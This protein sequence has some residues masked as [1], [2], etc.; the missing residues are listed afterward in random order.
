M[1]KEELIW[2]ILQQI[3]KKDWRFLAITKL[4]N[5]EYAVNKFY[6][7]MRIDEL[8]AIRDSHNE[9]EVNNNCYHWR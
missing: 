2:R 1:N 5:N 7:L 8:P 3:D 6:H 4:D 9:E